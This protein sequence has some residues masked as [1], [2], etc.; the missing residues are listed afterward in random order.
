MASLRMGRV[1]SE[2]ASVGELDPDLCHFQKC[3]AGLGSLTRACQF[4]TRRRVVAILLDLSHPPCP[5]ADATVSQREGTA[6]VPKR[7]G[8]QGERVNWW[9]ILTSHESS[10]THAS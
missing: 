6:V 5:N 10:P 3:A 9:Y 4:H 7:N 2:R 8:F 1:G